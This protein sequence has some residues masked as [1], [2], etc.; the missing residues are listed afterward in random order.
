[1]SAAARSGLFAA[2]I[3]AV[4]SRASRGP[5]SVVGRKVSSAHRLACVTIA[6]KRS[7]C[8]AIQFAM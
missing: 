3:S 4:S 1:M 2:R 5:K 6:R 8:P 7:V